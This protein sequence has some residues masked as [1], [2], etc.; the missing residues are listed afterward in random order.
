M[1]VTRINS[2]VDT[3]LMFFL[4]INTNSIYVNIEDGYSFKEYITILIVVSFLCKIILYRISREMFNK[5]LILLGVYYSIIIMIS[6]INF[7]KFSINNVLYYFM[8]FPLILVILILS[9]E[10]NQL[11]DW[12]IKFINITILLSIV[13][14][15]FWVLGSNLNIISPTDYLINKWSDGGVAVSYYNIY[16][17]TQRI[18]VMDNAIIRNS[19]IFAEAPM[20][21]L[22]LSIAIMI[23]TLFFGRN[24]Y[25]T[26]ILVLTI[27]STISTTGIYII[28]LIIAY[29]IIFEISGWKKYISLTLIPVLLIVLSIVW[30]EKSETAST[31]IRFDDYRAGIQAWL[32]NIVLGSGFSNGLKI[33]ESHM[34][35]T[36]R[37]NLGYSNSLFVI[38]AQGGIVLFILYFLPILIIMIKNQYSYNIKFF[39][40]LLIII[41]STTIFLDTYIFSFII[42]LMYSIVL[43]GEPYREKYKVM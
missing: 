15:F 37:P 30:Q 7:S 6:T 13:S 27:L 24:N 25:K 5:I 29:K 18:S 36:I 21:N 4:I 3:I 17:E 26:F 16:F 31:S 19:G 34:D 42:G 9:N 8:S 28:G 38:L 14:L 33:I 11:K 12:L 23:Q 1:V 20:W 10:Q 41:F 40:L 22:I 39:V 35:T 32:D 2:A 43:V